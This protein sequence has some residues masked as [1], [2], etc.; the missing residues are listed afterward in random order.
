MGRISEDQLNVLAESLFEAEQTKIARS[1]LYKE[2]PDL[3]VSDAYR[4]QMINIEKK[5]N[6]GDVITGKK[7][8]LTS[9]AMQE[10]AGVDQPDFGHLLSSMEVKDGVT[11]RKTMLQAFA[12]AE[13]AFVLKEDLLGP[14][15]TAEDVLMAT[16]YVVAA[17]EIVDSRIENWKIGFIDTV[18][19]NASSGRYF[20]GNKKVDPRAVD[21]KSITMDFY[22]NGIRL[23]GGKGSD[24]LGDP[25]AAVAWL[26]NSLG[27]FGVPLKKGEVKLRL[28]LLF[29]NWVIL[30][31]QTPRMTT[32]PKNSRDWL[33]KNQT[34]STRSTFIPADSWAWTEN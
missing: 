9:K 15:V 26:A 33:K 20:L 19:D 28:D 24:V 2:N 3:T 4:I 32:M 27:E 31:L 29:T 23:N 14:H 11:D 6:H 16:D 5:L 22:K 17:I 10:L 7:I 12:E 13:I 34:A 25:A 1:P 30:Q 21:L 18:S 8:G